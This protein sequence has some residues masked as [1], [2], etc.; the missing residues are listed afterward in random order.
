MKEEQAFPIQPSP[1]VHLHPEN[2][3][4][5]REWYAGKALQGMM[6][7]CPWSADQLNDPTIKPSLADV[8][9]ISF[10]AADAMLEA[11]KQ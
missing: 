11:A 4:T 6:A 2:G 3:L 9:R 1:Y 7:G 10:M 8:A 5:K